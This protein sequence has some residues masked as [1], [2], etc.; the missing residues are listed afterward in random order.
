MLCRKS[1]LSALQT[2]LKAVPTQDHFERVA[3]PLLG[4]CQTSS[5]PP[6]GTPAGS[7]AAQEVSSAGRAWRRL[8][9]HR[10]HRPGLQCRQT[11]DRRMACD[12]GRAAGQGPAVLCFSNHPQS[13]SCTAT[14]GACTPLHLPLP[15]S[16]HVRCR[17]G[18]V[19]RTVAC[20][21]WKVCSA[22]RPPGRG[23]GWPRWHPGGMTWHM[24]WHRR[25]PQ[26]SS[27]SGSSLSMRSCCQGILVP[28][29]L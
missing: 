18:R 29:H 2:A 20:L 8:L 26:A 22:S 25:W 7:G 9:P 5:A 12:C 13:V 24:H 17:L 6:R 23:L 27:H 15:Y 1:A 11:A 16:P 28:S 4:A 14:A 19:R 21:S 3:G 10:L